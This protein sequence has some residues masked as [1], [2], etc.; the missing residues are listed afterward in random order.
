MLSPAHRHLSI[1]LAIVCV[2]IVNR[3]EAQPN[4]EA[5]KSVNINDQVSAVAP[6]VWQP[7]KPRSQMLTYEFAIPSNQEGMA[8][9]RI[10]MMTAGGGVDANLNRWISQFSE[11]D[12]EPKREDS[13]AHGHKIHTIDISGTYQDRKGGPFGPAVARPD[14]RMQGAIIEG[15]GQSFFVKL[16]GPQDVM[17]AHQGSLAK[18]LQSIAP[19]K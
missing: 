4:A 9:V 1:L 12:G 2:L 13:E 5:T 18:F 14:Y 11:K 7:R 6:E 16:Y 17:D 10:T 8:D 19:A 15:N 3:A